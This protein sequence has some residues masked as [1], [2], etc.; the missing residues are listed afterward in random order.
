M[1]TPAIV[2]RAKYRYVAVGVDVR[3][4]PDH[5]ATA[6][7]HSM[8]KRIALGLTLLRQIEK[9]KKENQ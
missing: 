4:G 5:I 3:H 7:T 9:Q 1:S 8:A 2:R 6:H